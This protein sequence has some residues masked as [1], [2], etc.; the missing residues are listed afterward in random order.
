MTPRWHTREDSGLRLDRELR[1]FHD[2]ERIEHPR[3]VAAFNRGLRAEDDGRVTL[4]LG[5]DWCFVSVEECAFA[6]TALEVEGGARVLATLS[7]G[8]TEALEAMTLAEGDDGVLT[9]AVKGNRAR[10]RFSREA[11][12]QLGALL[13]ETPGGLALDLGASRLPTSLA[14]QA[15]HPPGVRDTS[16]PTPR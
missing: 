8:A 11:Q 3:V 6:V 7:D 5:S 16:T 14:L 13:V 9:V 15:T 2:G 1:W 12:A 4:H 10:A